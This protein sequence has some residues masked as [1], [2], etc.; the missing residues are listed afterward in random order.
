MTFTRLHH[1]EI[2]V[3]TTARDRMITA[4]EMS[5]CTFGS[6]STRTTA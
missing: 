6:G 4:R 2:P 5:L 1:E 3:L